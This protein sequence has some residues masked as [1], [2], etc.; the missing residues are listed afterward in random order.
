M[1]KSKNKNISSFTE[2]LDEQY[3]KAGTRKRDDFE[4]GFE[5]FKLG[6]LIKQARLKAH[7]TQDE[8]A[9]KADTKRSYISRIESDASDIRFSTLLRII[10]KG[11]GGK[12]NISIKL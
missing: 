1:K 5:A 8:L 11:L 7:M 4:R 10:E 2:H 3:G 6:V 9:D 12:L